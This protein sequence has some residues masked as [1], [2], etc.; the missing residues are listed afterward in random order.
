MLRLPAYIASFLQNTNTVYHKKTPTGTFVLTG[1]SLGFVCSEFEKK[2]K[3]G[4]L[5]SVNSMT[6]P[7][8]Y[9]SK[10]ML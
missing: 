6:V 9:S 5:T 3:R 8:P 1:V 10:R 2:E 4:Y 7:W